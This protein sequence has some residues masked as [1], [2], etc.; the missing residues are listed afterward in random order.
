MSAKKGDGHG[1]ELN[2]TR[3]ATEQIQGVLP[4]H[5]LIFLFKTSQGFSKT[6]QGTMPNSMPVEHVMMFNTRQLN[7]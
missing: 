4:H 7:A 3:S 2:R 1:C 6:E 5:T